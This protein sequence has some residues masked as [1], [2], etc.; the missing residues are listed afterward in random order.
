MI[1]AGKRKSGSTCCHSAGGST[2][3]AARGDFLKKSRA[4]TLS[5]AR[6]D[7]DPQFDLSYNADNSVCTIRESF[8]AEK[9]RRI[10]TETKRGLPL[11][12]ISLLATSH[13][14]RATRVAEVRTASLANGAISGLNDST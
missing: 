7:R 9:K 12:V 13:V 6:E 14:R 10:I 5:T 4:R 2:F 11:C 8:Y 3:R 1:I